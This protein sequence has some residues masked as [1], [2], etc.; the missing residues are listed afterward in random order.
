[1]TNKRRSNRAFVKA[2]V[3]SFF[4]LIGSANS[5]FSQVTTAVRQEQFA[6]LIASGNDEQR[7]EALIELGTFLS[8]PAQATP[9]TVSLLNDLLRSDSSPL[10]RALAVRAMEFSRDER[11]TSTLLAALKTEREPAIRQAI[12]YA[13]SKSPATEVVQTLLPMLKDKQPDIRAASAFSLAEI[14]DPI[15]TSALI[16]FLKRREGNEDAFARTQAVRGL[17]KIGD[18]ATIDP[19]LH[20]LSH[21]K[22]PEVKR[23]VVRSLGQIATPQDLKVI[24]ALKL[25]QLQSDPYLA[26]IATSILEKLQS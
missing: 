17:G 8:I 19:L 23:E 13:L 4:A 6:K 14:G 15:S 7:L 12:V 2:V 22:S 10:I 21:D 25:I 1:M 3:L 5:V 24:E 11:F 16:D 20:A 9:Q 18:R 26:S